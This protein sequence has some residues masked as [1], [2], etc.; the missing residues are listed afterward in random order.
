MGNSKLVEVKFLKPTLK[1]LVGLESLESKK[2]ILVPNLYL[3]LV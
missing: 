3:Q 2:K 1:S